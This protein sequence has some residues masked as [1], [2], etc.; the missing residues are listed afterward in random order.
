MITT[1]LKQLTRHI[2]R[3]D[4]YIYLSADNFDKWCVIKSLSVYYVYDYVFNGNIYRM[5]M[6]ICNTVCS[7]HEIRRRTYESSF[8]KD[9]SM[10]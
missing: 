9:V 6:N 5:C 7:S 8:I 10:K 4:N 3:V 1:Q 2:W